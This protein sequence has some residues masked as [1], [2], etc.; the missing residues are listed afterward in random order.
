MVFATPTTVLLVEDL[1]SLRA[2][3]RRILERSGFRVLAA[4]NGSVALETLE[5][6]P[7]EINVLLSDVAMPEVNGVVLA[8]EVRAR[9]PGVKIILMSGYGAESLEGMGVNR[10]MDT[11]VLKPF[12]AE[13]LV[14]AVHQAA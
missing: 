13:T 12:T 2:I 7:G 8:Q 9:F 1:D 5:Q 11:L 14:A 10:W 4:P 6:H 3:T